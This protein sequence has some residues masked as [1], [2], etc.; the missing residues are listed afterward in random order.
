M[1]VNTEHTWNDTVREISMLWG[2]NLSKS[3]F[4]QYKNSNL[5]AFITV[6]TKPS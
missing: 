6:I 5:R 2:K 4:F 3:H 1:N